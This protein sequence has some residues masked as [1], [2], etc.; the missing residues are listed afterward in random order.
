MEEGMILVSPDLNRVTQFLQIPIGKDSENSFFY[1][2][3]YAI[4]YDKTKKIGKHVDDQLE[5]DLDF[6]SLHPVSQLANN[7][8]HS[9]FLANKNL[10]KQGCFFR[11]YKLTK[12]FYYLI[13][14]NS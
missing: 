8:Q 1:A 6:S 13:Y 5:S 9:F 11:V 3:C 10:M 12:K 2:I 7:S 4:R 14:S